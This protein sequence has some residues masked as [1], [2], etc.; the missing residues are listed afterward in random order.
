LDVTPFI[1]ILLKHF[2]LPF[3]KKLFLSLT[4]VMV[5]Q[6]SFAQII[7]TIAGIPGVAGYSG[8]GGPATSA[9]CSFPVKVA[10]DGAGNIYFA[11]NA[12]HVIR[13]VD[14]A[15]IIT[16][17]AG[18]GTPGYSGDGGPATSANL[19]GPWGVAFYNGDVYFTEGGNHVVRK[20][21]GVTGIISNIAGTGVAGYSGDGGPATAATFDSPTGLAID[22]S[23]NIYITD[24]YNQRVR[25]VDGSGIITTYAGTGVSGFS[26]D[27]GPA[28][29]AQLAFPV[30]ISADIYGNLYLSDNVNNRIR[31]IDVNGIINTVAGTGVD[32]YN[33]DG[34]PATS[35][36]LNKPW[37]AIAD[38]SGNIYIADFFNCRIR[39]VDGNTG[40]ISTYAGS[41]CGYSGDGGLATSAQMNAPTGLAFDI[42][43]NVII[44]DAYSNILR[45]VSTPTVQPQPQDGQS[46][47][48]SIEISNMG[49]FNNYSFNNAPP[50]KWFS[51]TA[52]LSAVR[53]ML[54]GD[55][56][57]AQIEM[58]NLYSGN[59][60][61]LSLLRSDTLTPLD[62]QRLNVIIPN[63]V[64]G[65]VYYLKVVYNSGNTQFANLEIALT[66]PPTPCFGVGTCA[67]LNENFNYGNAICSLGGC[68]GPNCP[69]CQVYT[70]PFN[71]SSP[72]TSCWGASWGTPQ[73][74]NDAAFMACEYTI[75]TMTC[76]NT[77]FPSGATA[78]YSESIY[79]PF[80]GNLNTNGV[81][82]LQ[83]TYQSRYNTNVDELNFVL[84]Q[85]ASN[86]SF[87]LLNPIALINGPTFLIDQVTSITNTVT[88]IQRSKFFTPTTVGD[89]LIVYPK[90]YSTTTPCVV[91]GVLVDDFQLE[92]VTLGNSYVVCAPGTTVSIG[93]PCSL[94]NLTYSWTPA[95]GLSCASC[96]NPI[97]TVNSTTIYTLSLSASSGAT[98]TTTVT[99]QVIPS[100]IP[101]PTL[102]APLCHSIGNHTLTISNTQPGITYSWQGSTS[103]TCLNS[104]CSMVKTGNLIA[105]N[106]YTVTATL[107]GSPGSCFVTSSAVFTVQPYP[108]PATV[109]G[110]CGGLS[111]ATVNI[112]SSNPTYMYSWFPP[113]GSTVSCQNANCSAVTANNIVA[114]TQ[115]TITTTGPSGCATTNTVGVNV[116]PVPSF[117]N[118]SPNPICSGQTSNIA[119]NT[120]SNP[121][122]WTPTVGIANPNN[123]FTTAS[124]TVTTTYTWTA[125]NTTTGC[126]SKTAITVSV[127]PTPTVT[128]LP[129]PNPPVICNSSPNANVVLTA[130]GASTY[131]WS[132]NAGSSTAASVTVTPSSTTTY[133]VTGKTNNCTSSA[134]ITVTVQ[135]QC[136]QGPAYGPP[137][138]TN[139]SVFPNVVNVINSSKTV[140]GT[141]VVITD[142]T[143][144]LSPGVSIT[145]NNG[146]SLTLRHCHLLACSNMW[147]GIIVKPGGKLTIQGNNSGLGSMVE[148]AIE[149]VNCTGWSTTTN[150]LTIDNCVFNRNRIAISI[151]NFSFG[152]NFPATIRNAVFT[153]RTLPSSIGGSFGWS[154]PATPSALKTTVSVPALQ[155]PYALANTPSYSLTTMKAPNQ[156]AAS[157]YGVFL[158][159]VGSSSHDGTGLPLLGTMTYNE[160]SIGNGTNTLYLNLFDGIYAGIYAQTSNFTC[161]NSAFD[162]MRT[163]SKHSS[164]QPAGQGTGIYGINGGLNNYLYTR[165]NVIYPGYSANVLPGS[166]PNPPAFNNK[167]YDCVYAAQ[168]YGYQETNIAGTDVRSTQTYPSSLNAEGQYGFYLS[169]PIWRFNY[170]RY[171]RI[172]NIANG[173]VYI[174]DVI[175]SSQQAEKV[176]TDY[177]TITANFGNTPSTQFIENAIAVDNIVNWV[178]SGTTLYGGI[179]NVTADN[180]TIQHAYRGIEMSN[181]IAP[182]FSV[183]VSSNYELLES[184][185]TS[186][187]TQFGINMNHG[188]QHL[189]QNNNINGMSTSN[190]NIRG[191]YC[192]DNNN[193]KVLC[194]LTNNLGKGFEFEGQSPGIFNN[195]D[196]AFWFNNT[197]TANQRGF[198]L[199]N[200]SIIGQQGSNNFA[201][202]NHWT[203][204]W[205]GSNFG[206]YVDATSTATLSPLY[207]RSSSG[208][209]FPPNNGS[210]NSN[211]DYFSTNSIHVATN[212]QSPTSCSI[213]PPPCPSCPLPN[214]QLFQNVVQDNIT[215]PVLQGENAFKA[216]FKIYKML[217]LDSSIIDSSVVLKNFLHNNLN[218][219]YGK[220]IKIERSLTEGN[221][222]SAQSIVN[223]I[224]TT[225]TIETSYK[226]FYQSYINYANGS[227][228]ASDSSV[229]INLAKSCPA[230]YGDVV[231]MARPM[232]NRIYSQYMYF[233]DHCNYDSLV[234][235][236]SQ[237][238]AKTSSAPILQGSNYLVYPNPTTGIFYVSGF[239]TSDN[240]AIIELQDLTGRIVISEKVSITNGIGTLKASVVNGV[241][242]IIIKGADGLPSAKRLIIN[243]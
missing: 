145:V 101:A 27:G 67:P 164:F 122:V 85:S 9:L 28:N 52:Q 54:E 134:V 235:S 227:Y 79:T 143:F 51:F 61:S 181:W 11:D 100:S 214:L 43:G 233:E 41:S 109:T 142:R 108:S 212:P 232:Y 82:F 47:M 114:G 102:S 8:D 162:K 127:N 199:T 65:S 207:V 243:N 115:Y 136:N 163:E 31:K 33:G 87:P 128:I 189:I 166:Y 123:G 217:Q 157:Y 185:P 10:A 22:P 201:I 135:C 95:T 117:T 241:Y 219:S 3:M 77:A 155:A 146:A 55:I 125:T 53:L 210:T 240:E 165:A 1:I 126:S 80:T 97:A 203:G 183:S 38:A 20:V 23:G 106:T 121:G 30:G 198:Q 186:S 133:T 172:T 204:T 81:Y 148:D 120:G 139:L 223:S 130:S 86:T 90:T 76:S 193:Q 66:N 209:N 58:V 149:A 170:L 202:D 19:N 39:K 225:S 150:T 239:A 75:A 93:S 238:T 158:S 74:V 118:A 5:C 211:A 229:L 187:N 72:I 60:N 59:C 184:D 174:A 83:Y 236:S 110:L 206:T 171:N 34:I 116:G 141:N 26:G 159:N 113:S 63:L 25:K 15:G 119:V 216:K 124:P 215:Y 196:H 2:N 188:A 105:G 138:I 182:V 231:Y 4:L 7:S 112:V 228:S 46:C 44:V 192:K 42:N 57:N 191:V 64:T 56:N 242:M 161:V 152:S 21:N 71:S 6:F 180:N 197:M 70:D 221:I 175:N 234:L 37:D 208:Q 154:T 173:I 107:T 140:T 226:N 99:V 237:R 14:A 111:T 45:M 24:D 36:D 62:S 32:G 68:V 49:A 73:I 131:T 88:P 177:N 94:P 18:N 194:N 218:T 69:G 91:Q 213:A 156:I 230:I 50:S 12:N 104:S 153:C 169:S 84:A 132:A 220:F 29:M 96:A 224:N 78:S 168:I 195:N 92:E 98:Y 160:I 176:N 103:T 137:N 13:K 147:Q 35:A 17:I 179:V 200:S 129:N 205:S 40:L 190:L 151:N 89:E 16:T 144:Y 48:N 167:F 222:G 178:N